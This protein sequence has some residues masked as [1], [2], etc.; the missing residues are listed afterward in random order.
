VY[1]KS[2]SLKPPHWFRAIA[3]TSK[4]STF[5]I[6]ME[7][8]VGAIAFYQIRLDNPLFG[9]SIFFLMPS[10]SSPPKKG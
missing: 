9:L 1:K 7:I 3:N 6:K 8:I 10:A 4:K 2:H 5:D